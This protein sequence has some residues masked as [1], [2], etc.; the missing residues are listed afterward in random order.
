MP[1]T[2]VPP[3]GWNSKVTSRQSSLTHTA[4][5]HRGQSP[6]KGPEHRERKRRVAARAA[7]SSGVIWLFLI[8]MMIWGCAAG[9][10][11]MEY[12]HI[13]ALGIPGLLLVALH[14]LYF[15]TGLCFRVPVPMGRVGRLVPI[16]HAFFGFGFVTLDQFGYISAFSGSIAI[17]AILAFFGLSNGFRP[18][19][20]F[21]VILV[22]VTALTYAFI[23]QG[24]HTVPLPQ[25]TLFVLLWAVLG[26]IFTLLNGLNHRRKYDILRLFREQQAATE[27]IRQQNE[28]LDRQRAALESAN[29]QL[30]RMSMLDGLTKIA[31]RRRFEE[32]FAQEWS[33]TTRRLRGNDQGRRPS[34]PERLALLLIDIDHFKRFNDTY[35]HLA[36]D[37]CLKGV[38]V[39]L[40]SSL[41]RTG[42]LAARF[43]GEEFVVML[44]ETEADGAVC[45]AK[46]IMKA[47]EAATRDLPGTVTVSIGIAAV[48][49]GESDD[50]GLLAR[51]D[52]ALY[53]AKAGGRNRYVVSSPRVVSLPR[54]G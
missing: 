19:A 54:G 34:R 4:Y 8:G 10:T 23:P 6:D 45:V 13:A 29:T 47:V 15:R 16:M 5:Y 11:A 20:I 32:V 44:P 21:A 46:R 52:D 3:A 48:A 25:F 53:Q 42:D 41:H 7:L 49:E 2:A 28:A 30:K 17:P 14:Y 18:T 26:A 43:G 39:A 51:A 40:E 31:N 12:R 50:R 33:R 1:F 24:P 37:E 27:T 36:G 35:G 38:A 22:S 9:I